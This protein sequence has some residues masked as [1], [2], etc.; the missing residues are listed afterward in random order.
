M[1]I[2]DNADWLFAL[3]DLRLTWLTTGD[4]TLHQVL[5]GDGSLPGAARIQEACYKALVA[6][7]PD[8]PTTH[9]YRRLTG[10]D[11]FMATENPDITKLQ[12]DIASLR[13]EHG[14]AVEGCIRLERDRNL[15]RA[16]ATRSLSRRPSRRP[17]R[18]LRLRW[19]GVTTPH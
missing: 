19:S 3:S 15:H 8:T 11:L 17:S 2:P 9:F 10:A 4:K 13:L 7:S 18:S 6:F 14:Q 5:T 12:A 1:D 16:A